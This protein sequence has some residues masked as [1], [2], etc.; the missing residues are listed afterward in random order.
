MKLTK[1]HKEAF[2][3]GVMADVPSEDTDKPVH[4]HIKTLLRKNLPAA[5]VAMIDDPKLCDY[6]N[7]QFISCS[8]SV[9]SLYY[10]VPSSTNGYGFRQG[11][12]VEDRDELMKIEAEANAKNDKNK[13]LKPHSR[14]QLPR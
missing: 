9:N 14:G 13:N 7:R 5:V 8:G 4:D 6:L 10:H 1:Y 2:V 11:L 12:S 3:A